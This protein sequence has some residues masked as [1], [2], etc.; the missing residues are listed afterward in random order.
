MDKCSK[1]VLRVGVSSNFM[2]PNLRLILANDIHNY[3]VSFFQRKFSNQD[4]D[5]GGTFHF[6]P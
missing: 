6:H 1:L 5:T 2:V 3:I 4:S